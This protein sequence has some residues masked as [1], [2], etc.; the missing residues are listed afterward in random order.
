MPGTRHLRPRLCL[1]VL[2]CGPLHAGGPGSPA[3][4]ELD[5]ALPAAVEVSLAP[6]GHLLVR[7]RI[8]GVE[9]GAFILDTGAS[10]HLIDPDALATLDL[11]PG[12]PRLSQDISGR[13]RRNRVWHARELSLGPG[14]WADPAFLEHELDAL[15]QN[16][17]V[18]VLGILGHD[19]FDGVL[20]ELDLGAGALSLHDPEDS[21]LEV[22]QWERL[23]LVDGIPQ[24]RARYEG[25]EGWF[26]IDTG[27]AADNVTFHSPTVRR[28]ELLDGR[29][30]WPRRVAGA[31]GELSLRTGRL[32]WFEL[33]G[34]RF[35]RPRASFAA[36]RSGPLASRSSAGT[37]GGGF[38]GRFR[39]ILDYRNR[40][41]AFLPRIG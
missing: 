10:V 27:A 9:T 18:E 2:L 8:D 20:V 38:L 35:E 41:A 31:T 5:P 6:T 12:R 4:P 21:S 14:S 24:C 25:R 16:L 34:R 36:S 39:L 29:R 17:G 15:S 1:T 33:A 37:I 26:A 7:P 23:R 22:E 11:R 32:D 3:S 30:T 40:R 19:L 13:T 28:E